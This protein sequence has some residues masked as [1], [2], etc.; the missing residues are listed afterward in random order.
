MS[1]ISF[2]IPSFDVGGTESSFIRMANSLSSDELKTELVYWF[3]GGRLK[4]LINPD[5]IITRLNVSNLFSLLTELI[6]YFNR[7]KPDVIHSSMY[8]VGNI[9]LIARMLSK[10]KPKIIIGARSDFNSVCKTSKNS[11]DAYLLKKLS[12]I[13]FKR[14]DQIIAVSE[15][16]KKG[17]IEALDLEQSKVKVIYNGILTKIHRENV[18]K[19]PDHRWFQNEKICLIISIGRLSPEKGIYELVCAFNQAYKLN[20]NLRLMIIGEGQEEL[21]INEY[22]NKHSLNN[23]V[24][25]IGFKDDYFS[26]LKHSDIFVLNSYFEGMPSVLVE[27]VSTNVKIISTNCMHGPSELLKNVQGSTLIDVNNEEQLISSLYKFSK[28]E[29]INRGKVV[30]LKEFYIEESINKYINVFKG[31]L[32]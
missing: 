26:Y 5:V 4:K 16:V 23:C 31:L 28:I 2:I 3:E 14:S 9:A 18:L 8:M 30:H 6:K 11:F 15:G 1:K 27:A 22:I 17:L 25:I 10:H 21:K 32:K 13:L 19:P 24:E 20:N 12:H 29:N 7:S